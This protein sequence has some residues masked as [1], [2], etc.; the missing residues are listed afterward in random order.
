M[1]APYRAGATAGP[2]MRPS[3][4]ERGGRGVGL[5][6]QP[7]LRFRLEARQRLAVAAEAGG[8]QAGAVEVGRT[9]DDVA[10][11]DRVTAGVFKLFL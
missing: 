4:E 11:V 5:A 2:R 1:T 8:N 6:G 10:Q 9:V 3:I 7:T